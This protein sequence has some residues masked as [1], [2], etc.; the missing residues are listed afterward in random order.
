M[1]RLGVGRLSLVVLIAALLAGCGDAEQDSAGAAIDDSGVVV[2]DSSPPAGPTT[3]RA[4]VSVTV[5]SSVADSG[6]SSIV[7][8]SDTSVS[9]S[10]PSSSSVPASTSTASSPSTSLSAQSSTTGTTK[11][12]GTTRT[13]ASTTKQ[14]TTKQTTTKQ[15]ATKQTTTRQTTATTTATTATTTGTTATTTVTTRPT[16]V[17]NGGWVDGRRVAAQWRIDGLMEALP[18][19][20]YGAPLLSGSGGHVVYRANHQSGSLIVRS[21]ATGSITG[22]TPISPWVSPKGVSDDG[23]SVVYTSDSRLMLWNGGSSADELYVAP[24]HFPE[25]QAIS[26]TDDGRT[27]RYRREGRDD[28]LRFSDGTERILPRT[29]SLVGLSGNGSALVYHRV[30][31]SAPP[32]IVRENS[33]TGAT[34]ELRT[35]GG[36]SQV[37]D[38]GAVALAIERG[39]GGVVTGFLVADF[40]RS[41]VVAIPF[42]D[43][44]W[45]TGSGAFLSGDG[46]TVLYG[47]DREQAMV[48]D[49]ASGRQKSL[50]IKQ[51]QYLTGLSDNGR[52]ILL[53]EPLSESEFEL[54]IIDI[55]FAAL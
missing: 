34:K 18:G 38:D 55:D 26:L 45:T 49:I 41:S 24:S 53:A 29:Q 12:T 25:I 3:E 21:V 40:N 42:P 47:V 15:T 43:D 22:R 39:A 30:N 27:V 28:V 23:G 5:V 16:P 37:S 1:R 35:G 2:A 51:G 46:K 50:E 31:E 52:R 10:T 17:T 20:I 9:T 19:R 6:S 54:T 33:Q 32:A 36:F 7:A 14:T 4:Q 13:T 48:V 11:T 8:E 44:V